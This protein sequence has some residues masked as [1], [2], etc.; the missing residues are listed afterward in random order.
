M[1]YTTFPKV[2]HILTFF[3]VISGI[4]WDMEKTSICHK[5]AQH[6]GLDQVQVKSHGISQNPPNEQQEL[7]I[8]H[9][10]HLLLAWPSVGSSTQKQSQKL[11]LGLWTQALPQGTW[12]SEP[13][14]NAA[15]STRPVVLDFNFQIKFWFANNPPVNSE[16]W[17][18]DIFSQTQEVIAGMGRKSRSSLWYLSR[19]ICLLQR[20]S[21]PWWDASFTVIVDTVTIVLNQGTNWK[22][23]MHS[24]YSRAK[25]KETFFLLT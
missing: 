19:H 16:K 9:S 7:S 3:K 25:W 2:T 18:R 6:P 24:E 10:Y 20:V 22:P 15:P 1:H 14:S 5:W 11:G 12:A 4:E 21:P 13:S 17:M 8:V 23:S